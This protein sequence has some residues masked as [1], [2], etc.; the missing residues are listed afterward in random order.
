MTDLTVPFAWTQGMRP[1]EPSALPRPQPWQE[2]LW[3][4]LTG[5]FG[6][7]RSGN[8]TR[9]SELTLGIGRNI[10]YYVGACHPDFGLYVA[11]YGAHTSAAIS[12]TVLSP[13]DTGGLAQGH[14]A[15]STPIEPAALVKRES[16]NVG[17]YQSRFNDWVAA[18]YETRNDYP[19]G[20]R[21]GSLISPE[22][23][24]AAADNDGRAWIW[25]GRI[26]ALDL[27]S[28]PMLPTA[29]FF[30]PGRKLRYRDWVK[31]EAPMSMVEAAEH[32]A[33]IARIGQ[34]TTEPVRAGRR[35]VSGAT[36]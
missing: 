3:R 25:E 24:L 5:R 23:D 35:F 1:D 31:K 13:F 11:S 19:S 18:A 21:P 15:L 30:Q 34:E 22:I 4:R 36:L 16:Y 28:A 33:L 26:T 6:G 2:V 9:E 12:A 29:V 8:T 10:Y 7:L 27:P 32:L 20:V 14:V 17:D